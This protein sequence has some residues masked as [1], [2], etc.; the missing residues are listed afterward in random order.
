[1]KM[2]SAL[3]YT[4]LLSY[5]VQKLS[6][7]YIRPDAGYPVHNTT[8]LCLGHAADHG[9]GEAGPLRHHRHLLHRVVRSHESWFQG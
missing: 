5:Q 2:I 9:A 7:T 3:N 8:L 6:K 1:M 4:N